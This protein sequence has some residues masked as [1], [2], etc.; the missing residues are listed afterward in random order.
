[1]NSTK[2]IALILCALTLCLPLGDVQAQAATP[3]LNTKA[4]KAQN[5]AQDSF[6]GVPAVPYRVVMNR[7]NSRAFAVSQLKIVEA[8]GGKV[9]VLPLPKQAS[10]VQLQL[11][12]NNATLVA[13]QTEKAM[14]YKPQG[15]IEKQRI[16]YESMANSLGGALTS[17]QAQYDA[18]VASISQL[19]PAEAEAAM[20]KALP[21]LAL[22]GTR[23]HAAE[24]DLAVANTRAALFQDGTPLSQQLVITVDT[25]LAV[26]DVLRVKYSY[27]LA[28]SFWKPVYV[29]DANTSNDTINVKL[30]A[31]IT[32]NSD[33]DWDT[34]VEFS[35]ASGSEQNPPSVRPW[36]VRKMEKA[37]AR[38]YNMPAESMVMMSAKA[39]MADNAMGSFQDDQAL[40]VWTLKK[41]IVIPEGQTSLILQEENFKAP[42]Q[43]M[44]RPSSGQG[45][46]WL[47]AKPTMT[48]TFLPEGEASYL[49]D[50]V[51]VGQG[52]FQVKDEKLPLYFGVDP[53]VTVDIKKEVRTSDEDGIIHK[54]QVWNWAW[55]YTVQNKRAQAVQVRVEE[56]QTQLSDKAMSVEYADAP[57]PTKEGKGEDALFIWNVNVPAQGKQV[58]KRAVTVKAPK[59]MNVYPGK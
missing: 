56:P 9:V 8:M 59:D 37:Q 45:K 20:K 12:D 51:P 47:S 34:A 41:N 6:L 32:Q 2:K 25:D 44:A 17:L 11:P 4:E 22:I 50:G 35:T 15:F 28:D 54:E 40:A 55:T 52:I 31:E 42:L 3:P 24:R 10:Q 57:A 53:L 39:G 43:R 18:L 36:I 30:M 21:S 13:W 14:P 7:Q 5:L 48:S 27:T 16:T 1:M 23:M 33:L 58:I 26:G 29:F 49:L 46:V 38:T 19:P